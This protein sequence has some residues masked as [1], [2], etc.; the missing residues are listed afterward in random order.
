VARCL[1]LIKWPIFPAIR[2]IG[3]AEGDRTLDLCIA[4]AAL[5]Q[6]SYRPYMICKTEKNQSSWL[7]W[8]ARIV[9]QK[10]LGRKLGL[11]P[12]ERRGTTF[13]VRTVKEDEQCDSSPGCAH[14]MA[15][16]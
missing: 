8:Q 14:H 10:A 16:T 15:Y 6:L 1:G 5:S 9:K 11:E 13:S 2:G 12:S 3:G 4:N 7:A